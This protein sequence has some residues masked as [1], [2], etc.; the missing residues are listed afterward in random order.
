MK[1]KHLKLIAIINFLIILGACGHDQ[2]TGFKSKQQQLPDNKIVKVERKVTNEDFDLFFKNFNEN[3][4]FQFNRIAFPLQNRLVADDA[5]DNVKVITKSEW[6][7]TNFNEIK[8]III[9]KTTVNQKVEV[10]FSIED[11]GVHVTYYFEKKKGLWFLTTIVDE[12]D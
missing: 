10:L 4:K 6:E 7:Y 8:K 3:A 1:I 2:N 12:S 5:A 9:N 11:T